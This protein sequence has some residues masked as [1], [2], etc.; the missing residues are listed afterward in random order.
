MNLTKEDK[1]IIAFGLNAYADRMYQDL[2]A[3]KRQN[4]DEA[5]DDCMHFY[6][7]AKALAEEFYKEFLAEK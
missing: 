2:V 7:R 4:N 1:Q 3:Y 5:S 6:K